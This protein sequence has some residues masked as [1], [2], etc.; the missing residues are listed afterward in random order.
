MLQVTNASI[1]F[2]KE[3]LFSSLSFEVKKGQITGITGESGTGK[4]SLLNAIMGFVPLREGQITVDGTPLTSASID[5]IRAKIAWVPQELAL[6]AEWVS[7]MLSIPFDLKQNRRKCLPKDKNCPLRQRFMDTFEQLGLTPDLY[8]KRVNE[9]SGGQRQRMMIAAA[10]LLSKEIL[11]ADE[12]TSALDAASVERVIAFFHRL[13]S[14]GLTILAVSH[15]ERFITACDSII[16]L[17]K[18][19]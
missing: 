14:D 18:T 6:P 5:K 11:I 4:S 13:R 1:A 9:I 8:A 2:G 19:R 16:K 17:T 12:P 7:E 3:V 15:D 10:S